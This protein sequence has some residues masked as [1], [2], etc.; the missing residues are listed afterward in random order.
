MSNLTFSKIGL[1][2][3]VFSFQTTGFAQNRVRTIEKMVGDFV[4]ARNL[5]GIQIGVESPAFKMMK[6]IEN[7]VKRSRVKV[8]NRTRFRVGSISKTF[9]SI[10]IHQMVNEGKI[11]LEAPI[12]RYLDPLPDSWQDIKVVQLL[13]HTSGLFE[14]TAMLPRPDFSKPTN[15][16]NILKL[17]SLTTPKFVPGTQ[18]EYSN[19]NYLLLGEIAERVAAK[20]YSQ[21]I[22]ERIA[23]PLGLQN[24]VFAGVLD[25]KN[26]ITGMRTDRNGAIFPAMITDPSWLAGAGGMESSLEDMMKWSTG[27]TESKIFPVEQLKAAMT[28]PVVT[29]GAMAY[30]SGLIL[31]QFGGAPMIGHNGKL[32]GYESFWLTS[33]DGKYKL[34]ILANSDQAQLDP[35]VMQLLPLMIK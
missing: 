12:S 21:L 31:G 27:I 7:P 8:N 11:D 1:L 3:I 16:E 13:Q 29:K 19:T 34:V 35:L 5:Q 9:T 18:Q 28:P 25:S 4:V 22:G 33:L 30:G 14:Y 2:S 26:L 15:F 24:T 32:E 20:P 23:K 6:W 10:I 17:L